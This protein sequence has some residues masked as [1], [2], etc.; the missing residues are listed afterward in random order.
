MTP[1]ER[2]RVVVLGGGFAGVGAAQK[3]KGA[4]ADVVLV[5]RHDYHTFQPLLYQ[6]ATGLLE[7]TAVGHSLRDLVERQDNT[8][9][10]KATVSS[11]D[12]DAREVTFEDLPPESYDY[13]V[14]ALGAEVNFFG[15]EGAAEHAFPM[16]TLPNAMHLKDH[17]LER[18]E[19]ADHDP[20]VVEDGALNI[21]IVGGGPTGVETAGAVAELYRADFAKD[22][23][24][25]P[26]DQARVILVEA[27]PELFSMFKPKL[28]EYAAKALADRTVEVRT[29]AMVCIGLA[30]PGDAEVRRRA[31]GAHPGLGRGPAGE[32]A[33]PERSGSSCSAATGSASGPTLPFRTIPEVYALGDVAAI[34]DEKTQQVLPQLGSVALQS[35]EHAGESIAHRIAGKKTKP[36][37]YR[38]K[39]TMATIGRRAA[40][41]QM[42]GGRAM[43]G[44]K[45]QAAWGAVHLALLPTNEDR[46]KAIVD[47]AGSGVDPPTRRADHRGERVARGF[48]RGGDARVDTRGGEKPDGVHARLPHHP[49]VAG[50]G[51]AG[52]DADRQ[53]PGPAPQ[54]SRR[55]AS[56]R[57]AGRRR[58][59]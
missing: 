27:G 6:L 55:A 20:T 21:V 16:Y 28:R 2:P 32:P 9:V 53:L 36:F 17:L 23:P 35:G 38:D 29:G 58:W 56:S 25:L 48:R 31:E 40:V 37:K 12:L 41:V 52:D 11:V 13:L 47:W 18:W 54:R 10:H 57:S 4:D 34:V 43:T 1:A 14:F 5:D 22:Y 50:R 49:G 26:Q 15:T 45:A 7:T 3:L 59:R 24:E 30:D 19:A 39:G 51:A 42:L 33:R 44:A 8:T 46:A